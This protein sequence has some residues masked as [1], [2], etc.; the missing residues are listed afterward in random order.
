MKSFGDE[1]PFS[2]RSMER[3]RARIPRK[4]VRR[5]VRTMRELEKQDAR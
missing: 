5:A 2:Y 1:L 4:V 3:F